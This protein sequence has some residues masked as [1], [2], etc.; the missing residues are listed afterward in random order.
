MTQR[1]RR[2]TFFRD[3]FQ[4]LDPGGT[5][6]RF[7]FAM[8]YDLLD[9]QFGRVI[10]VMDDDGLVQIEFQHGQRPCVIEDDW[11]RDHVRLSPVIWELAEYFAG[12]RREFSIPFILRGTDFQQ[13]VWSELL[14]IPYGQTVTYAELA[15]RIGRPGAARA[16]GAANA[17]NL[18][19]ILVPCHRVIG[20]NGS[21][22]GYAAGVD[23]K[24]GLLELERNA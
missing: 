3:N 12:I 11:R 8:L 7:I 19:T 20:A 18:L 1:R 23:I 4:G 24:A 14:R 17:R 2:Y 9:T 21:L 6:S 13:L 5:E 10:A 16:I 22:T 15:E